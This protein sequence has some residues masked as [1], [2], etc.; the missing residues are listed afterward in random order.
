[1]KQNRPSRCPRA[2]AHSESGV[3]T[4]LVSLFIFIP[5]SEKNGLEKDAIVY[6]RRGDETL[7]LKLGPS[8]FLMASCSNW[9][10]LHP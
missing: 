4:N 2:G 7:A 3:T 5:P 10:I 9:L 1:M 8:V 6:D